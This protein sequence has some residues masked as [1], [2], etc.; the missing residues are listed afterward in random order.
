M[1]EIKHVLKN[2]YISKNEDLSKSYKDAKEAY[3]KAQELAANDP[4]NASWYY[5]KLLRL[6]SVIGEAD[7]MMA[8]RK[9]KFQPKLFYVSLI[10]GQSADDAR[11]IWNRLI[12]AKHR[13]V[14]W[15]IVN[16]Q[17]LTRDKISKIMPIPT[18]MCPVCCTVMETH[19]H[20]FTICCHMQRVIQEVMS[21]CGVFCWPNNINLWLSRPSNNLSDRILNAVV[22]ATLYSVWKSRNGCIFEFKCKAVGSLS[23]EIKEV[24]KQ[25]VL[26][27]NIR[28]KG[29]LD[30]HII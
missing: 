22:L 24:V 13:F 2:Y 25:R 29:A 21:W 15:Q 1:I 16:E 26:S 30:N 3:R 8:E 9:G 10:H 11:N 18:D 7:I 28:E 17:L 6:R 19:M 12:L 27:C 20:V 23:R 4:L 14:G 5:K